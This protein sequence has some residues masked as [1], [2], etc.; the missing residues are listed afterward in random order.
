M[1]NSL[2]IDYLNKETGIFIF[3]INLKI[4]Y[5]TPI[6]QFFPFFLALPFSFQQFFEFLM[7]MLNSLVFFFAKIH[8][9]FRISRE[10]FRECTNLHRKRYLRDK[11]SI[12]S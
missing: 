6:N 10:I 12:L 1:L 3:G 7:V 11:N 4:D 2:I 8:E 5:F 9:N